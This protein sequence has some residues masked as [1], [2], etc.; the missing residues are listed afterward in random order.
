MK[1]WVVIVFVLLTVGGFI[2]R[3]SNPSDKTAQTEEALISVE[4]AAPALR[5]ITQSLFHAEYAAENR[6]IEN[7]LETISDLLTNCQLIIKNFDT[8]FLPD[9]EAITSF[10]RGENPEKIAWISPDHSS[11]NEQGELMDRNK[12]PIFFHR[13][14][15]VK[16][17]IRSAGEDR[18]MWTSDDVIFPNREAL[19]KVN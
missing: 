5:V 4:P 8:F 19:P 7:D 9:N 18:E 11:I 10:L 12:I 3:L 13:E 6:S 16:T 1:K 14:S 17:Q 2:A 15:G